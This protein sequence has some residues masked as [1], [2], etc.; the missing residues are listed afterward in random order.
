MRL[1]TAGK[2]AIIEV[3]DNGCGIDDEILK[4]IFNPN[5]SIKSTHTGLG[6]SVCRRIVEFYNGALGCK[7]KKG[8]GTCFTIVFDLETEQGSDVEISEKSHP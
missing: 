5:F 2:K 8:E 1:K 7:T 3:E 6:L 4:N